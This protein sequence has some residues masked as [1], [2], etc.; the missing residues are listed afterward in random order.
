MWRYLK[1]HKLKEIRDPV[2]AQ[3]EEAGMAIMNL[4]NVGQGEENR[5]WL[6][7]IQRIAHGTRTSTCG[8]ETWL[9]PY[10]YVD[11]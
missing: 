11:M 3:N 6:V 10:K 4:V 8:D 2:K 7:D 9:Y 5:C 1:V